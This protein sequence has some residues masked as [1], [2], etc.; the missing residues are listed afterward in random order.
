MEEL[1]R[2][3]RERHSEIVKSCFATTVFSSGLWFLGY[4]MKPPVLWNRER[5]GICWYNQITRWWHYQWLYGVGCCFCIVLIKCI[6][7]VCLTL[8]YVDKKEMIAF[9]SC[10]KFLLHFALARQFYQKFWSLSS[11]AK[12]HI[13]SFNPLECLLWERK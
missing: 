5:N 11:T 10:R 9:A 12:L 8:S 2:L 3:R 4:K 13:K 7:V 6:V 1:E